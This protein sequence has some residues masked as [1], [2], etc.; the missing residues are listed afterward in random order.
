MK[1]VKMKG[2]LR[3]TIFIVKVHNGNGVIITFKNPLGI[4]GKDAIYDK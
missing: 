3:K 4:K 1:P 2:L